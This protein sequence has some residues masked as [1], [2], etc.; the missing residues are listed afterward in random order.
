VTGAESPLAKPGIRAEVSGWSLHP[1]PPE[2]LAWARQ[3]CNEEEF[4]AA[5]RE[6]EQTGGLELRDLLHELEEEP[7]RD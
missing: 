5:L 4:T 7:D 1:T 2:L 6:M 3:T